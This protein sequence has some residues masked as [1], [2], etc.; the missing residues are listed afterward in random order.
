MS[1]QM[2]W[3]PVEAKGKPNT[4]LIEIQLRTKI[5]N[6]INI[7]CALNGAVA[8]C[9]CIVSKRQKMELVCSVDVRLQSI[10]GCNLMLNAEI[11]KETGF[12]NSHLHSW[13]C[14]TFSVGDNSAIHMD[15]FEVGMHPRHLMTKQ[16]PW[17]V[18]S[19]SIPASRRCTT[20]SVDFIS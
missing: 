1:K 17:A 4:T 15:D 18:I 13:S 12:V 2:L 9:R 8:Y 6:K 16:L 7:I 14:G 5:K 3:E 20:T 19:D 11:M 10:R